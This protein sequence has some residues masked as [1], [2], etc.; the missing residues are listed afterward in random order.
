MSFGIATPAACASGSAD[1]RTLPPFRGSDERDRS[2]QAPGTDLDEL[3]LRFARHEL[4]SHVLAARS[5]Y[6]AVEERFRVRID[7]SDHGLVVSAQTFGYLASRP[8]SRPFVVHRTHATGTLV[9]T[10]RS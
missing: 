2:A 10:F 1:A 3:K 4:D 5:L 6:H 9:M 8:L 7:H